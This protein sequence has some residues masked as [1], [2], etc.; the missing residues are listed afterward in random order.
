[1]KNVGV[2]ENLE[3]VIHLVVAWS[4]SKLYEGLYVDGISIAIVLDHGSPAVS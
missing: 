1:M 3:T 4:Q 2:N